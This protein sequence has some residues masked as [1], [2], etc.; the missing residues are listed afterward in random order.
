MVK[1]RRGCLGAH[2]A[3][4][5]D[6]VA[7]SCLKTIATLRRRVAALAWLKGARDAELIIKLRRE[8]TEIRATFSQLSGNPPRPI[9]FSASEERPGS[10]GASDALGWTG[11]TSLI[12]AGS[13]GHPRSSF[14]RVS[15][16]RCPSCLPSVL[17]TVARARFAFPLPSPA[18]KLRLP[19]LDGP[20]P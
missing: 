11:V 4:G 1:P 3:V 15:H 16:E 20:P 9:T 6:A 7:G 5:M 13:D 8:L 12:I 19:L 10:R 18:A 14:S 2:S 17:C